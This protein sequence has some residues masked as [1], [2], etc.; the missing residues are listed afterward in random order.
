MYKK[1]L[2]AALVAILSVALVVGLLYM[3]V[4]KDE[5]AQESE[6]ATPSEESSMPDEDAVEKPM[7]KADPL[8]RVKEIFSLAKTGKVPETPF[9]A[10]K[11]NFNEIKE[12]WGEPPTID[13]TSIGDFIVY[14]DHEVTIGIKD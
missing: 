5:K 7:E 4:E 1:R 10:G 12:Q 6:Q 2:L 9:I 11:T 3:F 8:E 13:E 14:P